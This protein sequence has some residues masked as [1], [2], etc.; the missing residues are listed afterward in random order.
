MAP[1][2]WLIAMTLAVGVLGGELG[3]R[4]LKTAREVGFTGRWGELPEAQRL[5]KRTEAGWTWTFPG[6]SPEYRE[7]Q[8]RRTAEIKDLYHFQE[9]L[10]NWVQYTQ[11]GASID[12]GRIV[13][14]CQ[15]QLEA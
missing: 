3:Q 8:E 1:T 9:R 10:D 13:R 6:E 2:L 11:V 7:W 14:S 5:K 12:H 4:P 15:T